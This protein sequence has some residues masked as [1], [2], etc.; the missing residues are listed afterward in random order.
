MKGTK[1]ICERCKE[2]YRRIGALQSTSNEKTII[3]MREIQP[4]GGRNKLTPHTFYSSRA[5]RGWCRAF[6][7]FFPRSQMEGG[8]YET[9]DY[10]NG[11]AKYAGRTSQRLSRNWELTQPRSKLS[12]VSS[13]GR[14]LLRPLSRAYC[15]CPR[16]F[17]AVTPP[18]HISVTSAVHSTRETQVIPARIRQLR[19]SNFTTSTLRR[20]RRSSVSPTGKDLDVSLLSRAVS[21]NFK[22]VLYVE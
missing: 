16:V 8:L 15:G 19:T 13:G 20:V 6:P 22:Y 1:Y 14:R 18:F 2:H 4:R 5:A 9:L 12:R 3:S 10:V 17:Y 7:P 21:M 11:K